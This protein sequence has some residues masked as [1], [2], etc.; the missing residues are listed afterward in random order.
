MNAAEASKIYDR[1]V[2]WKQ[3]REA[4][5]KEEKERLALLEEA[6]LVFRNP[7]YRPAWDSFEESNVV[8][9]EHRDGRR[10]S[11]QP[12]DA[13]FKKSLEW[14]RAKQRQL[15]IQRAK[16]EA[17]ELREC[18]FRPSV[19]P[20]RAPEEPHRSPRSFLKC[21]SAFGPGYFSRTNM[22]TPML[23]LDAS[24]ASSDNL[25]SLDETSCG[26]ADVEAPVIF[27]DNGVRRQ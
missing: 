3:R 12:N 11:N 22:A 4:W 25:D 18:T 26:T 9:N 23:G 6:E 10:K 19:K 16:Q 8:G 17:L 21:A 14:S 20:P 13:F 2:K 7:Q 27:I 15:D 5:C 1:H 24:E